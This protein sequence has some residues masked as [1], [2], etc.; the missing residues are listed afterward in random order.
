MNQLG[1]SLMCTNL[2]NVEKDVKELDQ[3]GIDFYH[4]DVMD[5]NF[6]NNFTLGPDFVKQLRKITNTDIDVHIMAQDPDKFI[7]MFADA[8]ANRISLHVESTK[9]LQGALTKIRSLG[10]QVG[11]AIN[12]A[13]PLNSLKYILDTIDFVCLM[14]VNPGFAGQTFIDS[15]Y[16]KIAD[17][18]HMIQTSGYDVAIEV[19]GNIGDQTIPLCKENGANWYVG[20]TS[21]IYNQTGSLSQNVEHTKELLK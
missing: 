2:M 4:I 18:N 15:M 8:G 12:P 11:V 19:D 10:L 1:A 14:T 5:G 6:V 16:N 3:A 20:G 17:L 13:T 9:H 21:A 7:T